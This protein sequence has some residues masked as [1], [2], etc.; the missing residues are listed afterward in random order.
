[1]GTGPRAPI[2]SP[3]RRPVD[4]SLLAASRTNQ[5]A[6]PAL[7]DRDELG[8]P[9]RWENGFAFTPPNCGDGDVTD[10]CD[11]AE[12][13]LHEYQA[14]QEWDP[15][16]IRTGLK[17]L[18]GARIT[19]ESLPGD[20]RAL[21]ERQTAYRIEAE[22][23]SGDQIV[24]SGWAN[25]WLTG[26]TSTIINGGTALPSPYALAEL[27]ARLADCLQG[28]PGV[29]HANRR[30]VTQWQREDL[31]FT[32]PGSP[33]ILDLYGNLI[34]AGSGYATGGPRQDEVVSLDLTA[35]SEGTV[36]VSVDGTPAAPFAFDAAAATIQAALV[37]EFGTGVVVTES[38]A[39]VFSITFGSESTQMRDLT[40]T[41]TDTDPT[42][43]AALT[44]TSEGGSVV[45]ETGDTGWAYGTGIADVRVSGIQSIDQL[46][47]LGSIMVEDDQAA[48]FVARFAAVAWDPCC[49]FA[50][51]VDRC[52]TCCTPGGDLLAPEVPLL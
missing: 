23:W 8:R 44:V 36:T 52:S 24:A 17:C 12:Q 42:G 2:E 48:A 9:I 49:H 41:A 22:H 29:I 18:H 21:L 6:S 51:N 4:H 35:L 39:N 13:E 38:A 40:L 11:A 14:V 28:A 19:L 31:V 46:G 1:M 27:Q 3:A 47:Q 25:A 50:V 43:D 5:G 33:L 26:P 34:V 10:P 20:A 32:Q 16:L 15:F 30:F 7:A 37:A 45:D